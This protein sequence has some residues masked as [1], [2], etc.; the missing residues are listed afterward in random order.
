MNEYSNSRAL[1]KT[2]RKMENRLAENLAKSKL[3][4]ATLESDLEWLVT[5]KIKKATILEPYWCDGAKDLNLKSLPNKSFAVKATIF[6]GLESNVNC[7]NEAVLEGLITLSSHG[8][9]LK[10]YKLKITQGS[11]T[12]VLS[13]K[14]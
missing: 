3:Q 8:K 1:N 2:I 5:W 6:I 7:I 12:Y 14:T 10:R 4:K 13:K 9:K 11:A